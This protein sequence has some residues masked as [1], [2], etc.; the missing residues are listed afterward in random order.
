M[1]PSSSASGRVGFRRGRAGPRRGVETGR[2]GDHPIFESGGDAQ[3]AQDAGN[4]QGDIE[5]PKGAGNG[6]GFFG[7]G[8]RPDG[9]E[10]LA[11]DI[12]QGADDLEQ[13]GRARR[14]RRGRHGGFLPWRRGALD[15]S[16]GRVVHEHN[17]N[18]RGCVVKIFFYLVASS[19]ICPV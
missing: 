17:M 16:G 7:T 6:V 15:R 2:S 10:T 12:D 19:S 13:R 5:R 4:D 14:F 18:N 3:A 1:W 9:G 8:L 11:A